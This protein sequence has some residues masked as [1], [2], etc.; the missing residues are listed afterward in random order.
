VL[1]RCA[2][3]GLLAF[4]R[5]VILGRVGPITERPNPIDSDYASGMA[6]QAIRIRRGRAPPFS[7]IKLMQL[8]AARR[9]LSEDQDCDDRG[10]AA[11]KKL[12]LPPRY[13][14]GDAELALRKGL[15]LGDPQLGPS[16]LLSFE[17][18]CCSA[19]SI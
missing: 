11:D 14:V 13:E 7:T 12:D 16:L 15:K 10:V 2:L 3:P 4:P 19:W 6:R 9:R 17:M 8:A 18:P 1:V 5:R